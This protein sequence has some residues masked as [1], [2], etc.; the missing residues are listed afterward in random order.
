[1][2]TRHITLASAWLCYYR[3]PSETVTSLSSS[4]QL[5]ASEANPIFHFSQGSEQSPH[6]APVFCTLPPPPPAYP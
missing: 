1:M 6:R 3:A 4:Q 5:L 2:K